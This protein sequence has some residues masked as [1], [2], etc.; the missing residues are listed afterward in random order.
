MFK[1]KFKTWNNPYVIFNLLWSIVGILIL[2]GNRS[3]YSPSKIA[4]LCVIIGII[5]FNLSAVSIRFIL[6]KQNSLNK[7][8]VFNK[9]IAIFF[10]IIV[11]IASLFLS[12]DTIQSLLSG[13][14][15]S[16]IRNDYYTYSNSGSVLLY[17]LREY[18]IDPLRYVVIVS[19][20]FS[21]FKK[22]HQ[23]K[24]LIANAAF[25]VLLQAITSGG[26]YILMN[27]FFMLICGAFMLISNVELSLKQKVQLVILGG[28]IA[29]GIIFLTD[30]RS[31][32][33]MQSMSIGEKV[34]STIYQYFAG[35]VTYLGEVIKT[36]PKIK[37]ATFGVNFIA[38]LISPMFVLLNFIGIMSYPKVFSIIGMEACKILK[39]GESL[40]FNAM[41]TVF[42][43]S[44]ID[45]GLVL[46]FIEAWIWGYICRRFY[47][48]ASSGNLLFVAFYI[49]MFMQICNASTR[50]FFYS[51]GYCLAYVYMRMVFKEKDL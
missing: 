8:Y 51:T 40:Y 18:V 13:A 4:M 48:R 21:L 19:A 46:T 22:E 25:C 16:D 27:T 5:G 3:V 44:Y 15:Y 6:G 35:S 41:P 14:S 29:Y 49:L 24:L 10:S 34:L 47:K 26:R 28:L 17:Y 32:H 38:G 2:Y 42:G 1:F 31:T 20:I 9:R 50:W 7:N 36:T 43:Y 12:I 30:S 37:G 39:I 11:L 33:L 45:G 23:S